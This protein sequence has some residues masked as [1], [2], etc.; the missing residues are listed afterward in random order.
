MAM[1]AATRRIEG[2]EVGVESRGHPKRNRVPGN[3]RERRVFSANPQPASQAHRSEFPVFLVS[4]GNRSEH[5]GQQLRGANS[6]R[7][8]LCVLEHDAAKAVRF[9][10]VA[11]DRL[12]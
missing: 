2:L 9:I 3:I 8:K 10:E 5:L 4:G 11:I 6:E 7:P 12:A 1:T